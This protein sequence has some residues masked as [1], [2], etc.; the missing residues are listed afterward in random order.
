MAQVE[1]L[2]CKPEA[3]SSNPSTDERERER[4]REKERERKKEEKMNLNLFS[5][6][7]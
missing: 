7:I 1:S 4:E 6:Y 3:L 5:Q 2:S